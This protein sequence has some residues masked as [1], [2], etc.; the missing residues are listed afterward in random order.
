MSWHGKTVAGETYFC[1]GWRPRSD[2]TTVHLDSQGAKNSSTSN[3]IHN[4]NAPLWQLRVELYVSESPTNPDGSIRQTLLG[5]DPLTGEFGLAWYSD[6]TDPLNQ[7]YG[8]TG[9]NGIPHLFDSGSIGALDVENW[10][11]LVKVIRE[12]EDR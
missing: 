10:W 2:W 11:Y 3:V 4:L 7:I 9:T 1:T 6:A 8:Q 5:Y 12:I